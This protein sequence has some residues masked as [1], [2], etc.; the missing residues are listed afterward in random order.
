MSDGVQ[1]S[2]DLLDGIRHIEES[3]HISLHE[4]LMWI[5]VGRFFD[6]LQTWNF[7]F[8]MMIDDDG[9]YI[10]FL[11][12]IFLFEKSNHRSNP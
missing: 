2:I 8:G 12:I 10:S 9:I 7:T 4:P 5:L 11:G 1:H 3:A 6:I